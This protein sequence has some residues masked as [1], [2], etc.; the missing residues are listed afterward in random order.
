[1][2]TY[3]EQQACGIMFSI[4]NLQIGT[5]IKVTVRYN[6]KIE[7]PVSNNQDTTSGDRE[8]KISSLIV[9]EIKFL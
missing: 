3:D 9:R 6:L 2:K 7:W 5:Q 8:K 1:M 4:A